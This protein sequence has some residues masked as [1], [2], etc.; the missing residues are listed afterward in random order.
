MNANNFKL[1]YDYNNAAFFLHFD[2]WVEL[3]A[4][5]IVYITVL[6]ILFFLIYITL[7][8]VSLINTLLLD[9]ESQILNIFSPFVSNYLLFLI[10][11]I[12]SIFLFVAIYPWIYESA[13]YLNQN[14]RHL[15]LIS[16]LPIVLYYAICFHLINDGFKNND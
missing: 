1:F 7:L 5:L 15:F 12:Y 4:F 14:L 6:A 16:F 13:H 2:N 3:L 9:N 11:I 10:L 8:I